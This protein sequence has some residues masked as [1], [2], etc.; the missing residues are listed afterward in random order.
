MDE[1]VIK[2]KCVSPSLPRIMFLFGS[3]DEFDLETKIA[4]APDR[5]FRLSHRDFFAQAI[6]IAL[7]G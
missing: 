1:Y 4:A 3:G 6:R 7:Y 2:Y 5:K